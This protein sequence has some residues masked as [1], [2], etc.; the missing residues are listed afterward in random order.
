MSLKAGA[1]QGRLGTPGLVQPSTA[2]RHSTASSA[3]AVLCSALAA[4][5][6]ATIPSSL[7]SAADSSDYLGCFTT[8]EDAVLA[9]IVR[10]GLDAVQAA[11]QKTS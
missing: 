3:I 8:A 9:N 5:F 10:V 11:S 6:K 4:A 7:R 1:T 2:Q